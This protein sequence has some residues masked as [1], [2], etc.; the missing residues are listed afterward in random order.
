MLPRPS[1][2]FCQRGVFTR[3]VVAHFLNDR[4]SLSRLPTRVG[5]V[6][7]LPSPPPAL[8]IFLSLSPP[9]EVL[10]APSKFTELYVHCKL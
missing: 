7:S 8:G 1:S 3:R 6:R 2:P 5:I 9:R 4:D 10:V